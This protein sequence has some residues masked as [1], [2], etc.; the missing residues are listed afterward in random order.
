M[1]DTDDISPSPPTAAVLTLGCRVNQTDSG[2][3]RHLLEQKGYRA[4]SG[5]D[6]AAPEVVVINTCSVTL[7]SDRQARQLVRKVAR[8]HPD[9]EIV[10]TGCY[11][12]RAPEELRAIE[13][14]G[15]VLGNGEKF[16][17]DGVVADRR[18]IPIKVA[19]T[20]RGVEPQSDGAVAGRTRA[21]LQIQNG[22]DERCTFCIVPSVRGRSVSQPL[23]DIL[24]Q[25]RTLVEIGHGEIVLTGINLGAYGRDL[26]S[27]ETVSRV[28]RGVLQLPGLRRLRLSSIDPVDVE[29]AL[30]DLFATEPRLCPHLH[31][32]VQSGDDTILKRMHR[33][34]SRQDVL[35]RIVALR[36]VRPEITF[37]AD[38][39]VGF[40]TES[41]EAFRNSLSLVEQGGIGHLHVFRYSDRPGVAA[42]DIPRRFRVPD[43]EIKR[44]SGV[45]RALGE[46]IL[47]QQNWRMVGQ[48]VPILVEKRRRDGL[49][50]G[51]SAHF[52][53][54]HA[55]DRGQTQ[56]GAMVLV[57][58]EALERSGG[59]LMGRVVDA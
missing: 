8:N 23:S 57:Q 32:S 18:L 28:V 25:A 34:N 44:R 3:I 38:L 58:I 53:T 17:L 11:A 50:E 15:H 49:I 5:L 41:P 6:G 30:I 56:P 33:R 14:V 40:P 52:L 36:R 39:I 7:E 10:V 35:D 16:D 19:A 59:V 4:G 51:H 21:T 9:A 46:R 12:Q 47:N 54:V 24:E 2:R 22:C 42:A 26:E 37:G 27:G 31:L 20:E 45:L 55:L 1:S 13:G 48:S 43:Q 29:Q